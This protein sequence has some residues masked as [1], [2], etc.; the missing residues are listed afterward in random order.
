MILSD[1]GHCLYVLLRGL[2]AELEEFILTGKKNQ[3][4]VFHVLSKEDA[5]MVSHWT[6][7]GYEVT[8]RSRRIYHMRHSVT[9][10]YPV[11]LN[12]KSGVSISLVPW[13]L[14]PD[15]PYPV[16]VY[17]FAIWHYHNTGK[18]SLNESA[19]AAGKVFRVEQFNKSTVYRSIKAMEHIVDISRI[20]EPLSHDRHEALSCCGLLELIPEILSGC[21]SIEALQEIYG[22]MIKPTPHPVRHKKTIG[23][24]LSNIPEKLSKVIKPKESAN[25]RKSDARR[26]PARPRKKILHRVQRRYDFVQYQQIEEIRAAFVEACRHLVLD[27][28]VKYHCFLV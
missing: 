28:A 16:F 18:K 4:G 14:L 8:Y 24:V 10:V 2:N 1:G 11:V 13:F 25:W 7:I 26:R 21:L 12:P 17:L 9:L 15:R 22:E 6:D 19:A 20:D 23:Y 3:D 5:G 27:A